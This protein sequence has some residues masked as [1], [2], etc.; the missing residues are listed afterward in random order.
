MKERHLELTLHERKGRLTAL[1]LIR[2]VDEERGEP[3]SSL[4]LCVIELVRSSRRGPRGIGIVMSVVALFGVVP[5][6]LAC[7]SIAPYQL[8]R[9]KRKEKKKTTN[10][11]PVF[12]VPPPSVR[13]PVSNQLGSPL[14]DGSGG[15]RRGIEG[16][17]ARS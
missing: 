3:V 2:K 9:K 14:Q 11:Q 16:V 12:D 1:K 13:I 10:L 15:R 8:Q 17:L 7:A 6:N 4:Y 5:Y